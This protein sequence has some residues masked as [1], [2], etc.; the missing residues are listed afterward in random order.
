MVKATSDD[1]RAIDGILLVDKPSGI[2]SARA[3]A[4]AKR[5]LGGPKVGHLG[6]LD[7]LAS[8]LLPLCIGQ[9]TKVAPYLN[10]ADKA[11]RGVIRLGIVTDTLDVTGEIVSTA[12][13]PDP[14]AL[15]LAAL[16]AAFT[17]P[18][19]QVPPA[20][21]AIKRGGVRMYELAR[22]GEAP[23]LEPRAVVIHRLV[24]HALGADR[25]AIELDCSKGTYVRSLARD[26]GERIG[27]GATLEELVRT[28]FGP[29]DLEA[30]VSLADLEHGGVAQGRSAVL[31]LDVAL[32]H[33][34]AIDVDL[35]TASRLRDGQQHALEELDR[36]AGA[37]EKARV[38]APETGLVAVVVES[39][40]RWRLDRVFR[41]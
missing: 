4:V 35:A 18:L 28:R 41:Y 5:A 33:L 29:F 31:P 17:G 40:G 30:A 16:G 24:L 8:G 25:L 3:V 2:S 20:F 36:P 12:D 6:T 7:P 26:L 32:A 37:G 39:G 34:R 19:E 11:Y 38:R 21:S 27:C 14:A 10:V 23:V 9:G 13:A 15:D 22:R 1:A